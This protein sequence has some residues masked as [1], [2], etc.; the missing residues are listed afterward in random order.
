MNS[1]YYTGAKGETLRSA[2]DKLIANFN[3]KLEAVVNYITGDTTNKRYLL[4]FYNPEFAGEAEVDPKM[5]E[6]FD[7]GSID[8]TLLLSPEISNAG[9]IM[10]YIIKNQA[11]DIEIKEKL[12]F[13]KLGWHNINGINCYC[14]GDKLISG[15][16]LDN[17]VISENLSNKYHL[18]IDECLS[19][20]D[21][22]RYTTNLINIEPKISSLIFVGGLLGVMRQIIIDADIRVP[23]I[24]Y[25]Y[26]PSQTRKTT[27]TNLSVRIYNRSELQSDSS[28]SSMRVSSSEFK[29]EELVDEL[30]DATFIF[31]DL[32]KE[33][34]VK[35]R[36]I[37]EARVRNLI[38]NF[39]D[40]SSRTTA[41]S[42]FKNNCQ[43]VVT[44]EYLLK[45]KTDIGRTM[46]IHV[47]EKINS[48]KLAKCQSQ[49]LAL[50]TFYYYFIKWLSVNY[51]NIV[52]RLKKEY[53]LFRAS[54]FTH[55][56]NF[57]RLY[58]QFFLMNFVFCIYLDYLEESGIKLARNLIIEQFNNYIKSALGKQS[59]ILK[60]IEASEVEYINLSAELL[61][62]IND[63]T[64]VVSEKGEECFQKGNLIYIRNEYFGRKLREKYK[65]SFSAKSITAYFRERFIS[66]VYSDNRTKKY[67]NKCYLILD[68]EELCHDAQNNIDSINNLF[69]E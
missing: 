40:N 20:Y 56:G 3:V 17:Y 18:E 2:D 11:K 39:A 53:S 69:F 37:Y 29:S 8:D 12:L 6:K 5:L 21:A 51:D 34:S 1:E 46:L 36:K 7:Y 9:K 57:E 44:A 41:R 32:Y 38:R 14:A 35:L 58:E 31:D 64:I 24:I 19:E 60:T 55:K 47:P 52:E 27:L 65:K 10:A 42:A 63:N 26:G 16:P 22:G 49:P 23:C 54:S 15:I 33:S 61:S 66:K 43:I 25:V 68:F 59:E 13:N 62:M 4:K 45:S 67:N 50:S 28:V 48:E 30:K